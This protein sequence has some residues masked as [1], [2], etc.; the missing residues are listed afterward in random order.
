MVG[1][2][3]LFHIGM[4]RMYLCLMGMGTLFIKCE[5]IARRLEQQ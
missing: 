3:A 4:D 2:M 1:Q 5:K